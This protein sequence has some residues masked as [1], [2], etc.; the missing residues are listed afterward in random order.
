MQFLTVPEEDD[1][2]VQNSSASPI[3]Q[4]YTIVPPKT[5]RVPLNQ[6]VSEK[7]LSVFSSCLLT[8]FEAFQT[9]HFWLEYF[10]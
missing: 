9:F 5:Y 1:M 3:V 10:L 4:R 8:F 6:V 7:F 2:F